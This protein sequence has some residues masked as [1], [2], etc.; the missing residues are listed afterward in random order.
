MG[1]AASQEACDVCSQA[2]SEASCSLNSACLRIIHDFL[3]PGHYRFIA[4]VSK[5][6]KQSYEATP[7]LTV[8]GF[9]VR[10][11]KVSVLCDSKTT[12]YSAIFTS[13]SRVQRA[14][15][16]QRSTYF[17]AHMLGLAAGRFAELTVLQRALSVRLVSLDTDEHYREALC[18]G[19][20][21]AGDLAKLQWLHSKIGC[22]MTTA[23][24][25]RAASSGSIDVLK[26]LA[27]IC[28]DKVVHT[29]AV[30]IAA[31]ANGQLET[32]QY[33]V[34]RGCKSHNSDCCSAAAKRGHLSLIKW[35]AI[36]EPFNID[37]QLYLDCVMHRAAEGG[38][39]EVMKWLRAEHH[40]RLSTLLLHTA[41]LN[42]QLAVVQ[43]LKA[44]G[45]PWDTTACTAAASSYNFNAHFNAR[46]RGKTDRKCTTL[47]WLHENGCPWDVSAVRISAAETGHTCALTYI[48]HQ[49][50]M[51]DA[52]ELTHML[53]AAG[54][55]YHLETVKL[56]REIG[57][58]WPAV[59]QYRRGHNAR[60][61]TPWQGSTLDWARSQGCK[62]KAASLF[63]AGWLN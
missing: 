34:S 10:H 49:E 62:S 48:L 38:S 24:C 9:D 31:C 43:Y 16:L 4:P 20:A 51:P 14:K 18:Y 29:T 57:A 6:W 30:L 44:E 58:E 2:Q 23:V 41:A 25:E 40:A 13:T 11:Y 12:L 1:C 15:T 36:T 19:A 55:C 37:M 63:W 26:W 60:A 22:R 28:K 45:C 21:L 7:S 27:T 35:M 53:N 56:L 50:G 8:T 33:L 52:A 61:L 32:V 59:L 42:E 3:G 46:R 17:S 54:A 47:Q 5:L 39:I